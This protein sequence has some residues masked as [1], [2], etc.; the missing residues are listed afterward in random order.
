M[1]T[2]ARNIEIKARVADWAAL[3][4]KVGGL[5]QPEGAL[6]QDDSFFACDNGR[7]KLRVD[8]EG[9]GRLIFYRREDLAGLKPSFFLAS[10]TAA[11]DPL[12]ELLAEA[13]GLLGRVRKQRSRYRL[14]RCAIHLDRVEGLGDF[15][16]LEAEL[17][18]GEP[19]A[20][21]RAE[22]EALMAALGIAGAS[23]VRGAY[24]DLQAEAAR[25]AIRIELER[26]DQPEVMALIDELDA[27]QKPL[28]PPESHHGVDI[29]TLLR[30]DVAFAVA[31]DGE[32]RAL[33]CGAVWCADGVGELKRMFVRP[34]WRGL[35]VARRLMAFLEDQARA[36]G[37]AA[38]AL[39]TG[40]LQHDAI[41]LYQRAGYGFCGP[42]GAYR[43]DPHSV[44]MQ[45]PL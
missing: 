8:G 35:G 31:R 22:I 43:E 16:E 19:E 33:G 34:A 10:E 40:V 2:V 12:R 29:E 4:R 42:F 6:L 21:A 23:L 25:D 11:P 7:L 32:G 37:C 30:P 38:M 45:K 14:G 26:A 1:T 18:D 5:A 27:Y 3:E 17:A 15:I 44:F 24:L 39:E 9:R 28:S 20:A 13:H 36:R 41:T